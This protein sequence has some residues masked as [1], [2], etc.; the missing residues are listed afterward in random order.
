MELLLDEEAGLGGVNFF[1]GTMWTGF[2][3]GDA[4]AMKIAQDVPKTPMRS[5]AR[6]STKRVFQSIYAANNSLTAM[7]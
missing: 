2:N 7:P 3:G 5:N 6:I 4:L 1:G